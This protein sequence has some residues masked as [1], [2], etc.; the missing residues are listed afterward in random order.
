MRRAKARSGWLWAQQV[1]LLLDQPP[2]T[3]VTPAASRGSPCL[4]LGIDGIDAIGEE[5]RLGF[6]EPEEL[7]TAAEP[8]TQPAEGLLRVVLGLA[9][10]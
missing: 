4:P 5:G 9:R 7:Q 3:I 6:P 8:R 2:V 10:F 1:S